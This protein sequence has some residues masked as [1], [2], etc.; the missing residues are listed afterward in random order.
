MDNN[1][2]H[3]PPEPENPATSNRTG[4]Y[5]YNYSTP[6]LSMNDTIGAVFLGLISLIMIF[7]FI[8]T[9]HKYE[10]LLRKTRG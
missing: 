9:N 7:L 5:A 2:A 10:E 1:P 4:G 3:N 8:R 6:F